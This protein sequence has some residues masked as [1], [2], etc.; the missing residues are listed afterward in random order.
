MHSQISL[1]K[2]IQFTMFNIH[3]TIDLKKT[4]T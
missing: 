1:F 4:H 2:I 3:E